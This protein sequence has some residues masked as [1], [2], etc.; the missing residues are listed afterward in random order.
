MI[1]PFTNGMRSPIVAPLTRYLIGLPLVLA[2]TQTGRF[3]AWTIEPPLTA[4]VLGANYWSSA[5]FA[6]AASRERSWAAG[7]ISI[8]V[9]VVFAP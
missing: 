8:S 6:V 9:A 1:R 3:F 5:L 7:R 4:A 2:P